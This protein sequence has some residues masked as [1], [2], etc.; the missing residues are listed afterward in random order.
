M[1]HVFFERLEN[2]KSTQAILPSLDIIA[3]YS[4][5]IPNP[6]GTGISFPTTPTLL[7]GINPSPGGYYP[8][9]PIVYYGISPSP[10]GY[11]PWSG[12]YY[13]GLFGGGY[14]PFSPYSSWGFGNIFSPFMNFFGGLFGGGLF[15]GGFYPW[16]YNPTFPDIRLLYGVFPYQSQPTNIATYY[17]L[18]SPGGYSIF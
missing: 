5:Q 12:G 17:G 11:Y 4:A 1:A 15:G 10:G 18:L 7:Y 9:N 13:G 16:G 2:R 14:S 8:S 6:W 3:I